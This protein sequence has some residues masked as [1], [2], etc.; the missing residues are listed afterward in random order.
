MSYT[1]II[2]TLNFIVNILILIALV[3][4]S[5]ILKKV[6]EFS[7]TF[8]NMTSGFLNGVQNG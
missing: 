7:S 5:N 6:N 1:A 4:L 3:G 2:V 8:N